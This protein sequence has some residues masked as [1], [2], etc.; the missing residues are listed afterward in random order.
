M[1]YTK[2]QI[3]LAHATAISFVQDAISHKA[4]LLPCI[5]VYKP[6]D[7]SERIA[8]HRTR[9]IGM[10]QMNGS[11]KAAALTRRMIEKLHEKMPDNL[12]V[13][14]SEVWAQEC[15]KE[16]LKPNGKKEEKLMVISYD[17]VKPAMSMND[18]KRDKENVYYVQGSVSVLSAEQNV[19]R[20]APRIYGEAKKE[21]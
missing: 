20:L 3:E 16:S 6:D 1:D 7:F 5:L 2:E 19:G 13:F 14:V 15:D 21:Q 11:D 8:M 17:S 12:L 18:I 10:P 9:A 4:D